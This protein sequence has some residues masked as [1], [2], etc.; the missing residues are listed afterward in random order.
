MIVFFPVILI[1]IRR[2]FRK[3]EVVIIV[4]FRRCIKGQ[5]LGD[6][7]SLIHGRIKAQ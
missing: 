7:H 6:G 2:R 3:K 5:I 1:E 4:A